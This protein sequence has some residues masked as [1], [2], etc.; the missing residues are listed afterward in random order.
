MKTVI[1]IMVCHKGNQDFVR[2]FTDG[3]MKFKT[4]AIADDERIKK[5]AKKIGLTNYEVVKIY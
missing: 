5:F 2:C 4:M 1:E 3:D